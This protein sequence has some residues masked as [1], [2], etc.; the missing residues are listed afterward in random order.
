M[1]FR[2]ALFAKNNGYYIYEKLLKD[3]FKYNPKLIIFEI[4]DGQYQY[5]NEKLPFK[6]YHDQFNRERCLVWENN[7]N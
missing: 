3:I 1:L 5:L 6:L 4:G 2:S 7:E